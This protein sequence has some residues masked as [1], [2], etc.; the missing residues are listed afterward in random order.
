MIDGEM[1]QESVLWKYLWIVIYPIS[2][3]MDMFNMAVHHHIGSDRIR[4][5][6][7]GVDELLVYGF[8]T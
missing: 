5:Q 7:G 3:L 4:D 1:L 6:R 8:I 2:D